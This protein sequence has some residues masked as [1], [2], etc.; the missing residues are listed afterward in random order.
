MQQEQQRQMREAQL[1]PPRM[2][3]EMDQVN[4]RDR[5]LLELAEYVPSHPVLERHRQ[6][7]EVARPAPRGGGVTQGA[8]QLAGRALPASTAAQTQDAV[9]GVAWPLPVAAA[10][11]ARSLAPAAAPRPVTSAQRKVT[12]PA[13]A[14]AGQ[15]GRAALAADAA[16]TP[17]QER[18]ETHGAQRSV[19]QRSG[20]AS[21]PPDRRDRG[22]GQRYRS[23]DGPPGRRDRG[24]NGPPDRRDRGPNGT[25][26]QAGSRTEW[27]T[28]PA[29]SRTEWTTG[30]TR[31]RDQTD[32]RIG[33]IEDQTDHQ[34]GGIG[35]L[36]DHRTVETGVA[37]CHPTVA[38]EDAQ[39]P[40]T[41]AT[42]AGRAPPTDARESVPPSGRRRL[43]AAGEVQRTLGGENHPMAG[44]NTAPAP[45]PG[46]RSDAS[47]LRRTVVEGDAD[48]RSGAG[49]EPGNKFETART[50]VGPGWR[51][52]LGTF[53]TIVS[54]NVV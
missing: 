21:P 40:P 49:G 53:A 45:G 24:P 30:P 15:E 22:P 35:G 26:G 36:M 20:P 17:S 51:C 6:A 18:G 42:G 2:H 33:E 47:R 37:P 14:A 5:R 19:R 44:Q 50:F 4:A 46:L 48:R 29:G 9:A 31:S 12:A 38:T 8:G 23:P 39:S 7:P 10:A 3:I 32:H 11:A 28:G 34:T 41:N 54:R 43:K 16:A 1:P 52:E 13:P 25:T 27:T